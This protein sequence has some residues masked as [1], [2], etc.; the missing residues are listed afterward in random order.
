MVLCPKS[1]SLNH[2]IKACKFRPG[3]FDFSVIAGCDVLSRTMRGVVQLTR[4]GTKNEAVPI[5][6]TSRHGIRNSLKLKYEVS[7]R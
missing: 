5:Q 1:S 4:R 7:P 6:T 2:C 3:V